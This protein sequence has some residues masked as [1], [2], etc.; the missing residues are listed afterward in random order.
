MTVTDENDNAPEITTSVAQSVAE[1]STVVAGLTS[2]DADS[3]GTNPAT[4]SITGGTDAVLFEIVGSNL[5]FKA[6]PDY[7]TDKHSYEVEV[8]ADDGSNTTAGTITVTVTDVNEA[9]TVETNLQALVNGA[10][11]S[12]TKA[13]L[14]ADD[15]DNNAGK[16]TYTIT[17][18][19]QNGTVSR[20]GSVLGVGD[21][22]TQADIEN[23]FLTYMH[24]GSDTTADSFSFELTDG[25]FTES[26]TVGMTIY[27]TSDVTQEEVGLSGLPDNGVVIEQISD[28]GVERDAQLSAFVASQADSLTAEEQEAIDEKYEEALGG[29]ANVTVCAVTLG[30]DAVVGGKI[31]LNGSE[32]G[33]EA[34][35][36]DVSDLPPGTVLH[37]NDVEFAVIVGAATLEGG[38]GSNI[39]FADGSSQSIVL[40]PDDDTIHGGGGDDYIGSLGGNDELYGDAGNDTLSGGEGNDTLVGGE[41]NDS[42]DG[43]IGD[44][45]VVFSGNIADYIINFDPSTNSYN[46]SHAGTGGGISKTATVGDDGTDT[47]TGV[48]HFKFNDG[49]RSAPTITAFNPEDGATEVDE[50]SDIIVTFSEDI[51][52]GNGTIAIR[53]SSVDGTLVEAFDVNNSE[54]NLSIEG[55]T[56]TIDPTNDLDAGQEYYITFADGSVLDLNG[57]AYDPSADNYN[58]TTDAVEQAYTATSDDSGFEAGLVLAGIGAVAVIALII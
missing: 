52:F 47:V 12:I 10:T 34:L 3:V 22:F 23:G 9:P 14:S 49:T 5:Q 30:A 38:S 56:L 54:N 21:T 24:D 36:I 6:A 37:F 51:A 31:T 19:S 25:E 39:V 2:T 57:F 4:F 33:N 46:I 41:G 53:E 17:S 55:G 58:F 40:G 11:A 35:V 44:D 32:D 42:I 27:G 48:E 8:T 29:A 18:A 43:G 15:P 13:N 45:T 50:S 20:N 16:L 7:E 1:N 28:A 26:G